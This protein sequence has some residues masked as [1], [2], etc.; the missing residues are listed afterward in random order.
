MPAQAISTAAMGET[1]R[2]MLEASCIGSSM[3]TAGTPNL[4]ATAGARGRS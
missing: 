1:V 4:A 3:V 2:P